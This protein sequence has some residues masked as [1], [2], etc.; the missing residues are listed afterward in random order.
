MKSAKVYVEV[1]IAAIHYACP[2]CKHIIDYQTTGLPTNDACHFCL[3]QLKFKI[4]Y[5]PLEK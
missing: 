2:H 1:K 4:T 3:K 5:L